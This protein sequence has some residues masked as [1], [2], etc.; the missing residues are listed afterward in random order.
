VDDL[1]IDGRILN[2]NSRNIM[3]SVNWVDLAED[4]NECRAI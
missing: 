1:A 2:G 3:E 4:I